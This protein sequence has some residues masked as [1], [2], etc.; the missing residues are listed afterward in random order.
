MPNGCS[1]IE[2]FTS[3]FACVVRASAV[4]A[5]VRASLLMTRDRDYALTLLKQ[6]S[7]ATSRPLFLFTVAGRE[8]YNHEQVQ[9]EVVGSSANDPWDLIRAAQGLSGGG[10]VA[11]EDMAQYLGDERGDRRVRMAIARML[12]SE[13]RHEGGLTLVFVEPPEM[14]GRLPSMLA[15]QIVRL[16]VPYPRSQEIETIAR[17]ELGATLHRNRISFTVEDVRR[18]GALLASELAGLTR[19][20]ARDALRDVLADSPF[21]LAAGLDWLERRKAGYL[22]RELAMEILDRQADEDPIGLDYLVEYLEVIK[23]KLRRF[24]P[25]R[26]RGILLIGPPGTGKTLLARAIG[27]ITGLEPVVAFRIDALMNSLLGETERRFA[28]AFATLEAMAPNIVFIDELEK[29]FGD[30]S[31][32]DGGTMMRVTGRLLSWLSDNPYPNFIVATCN[33]LK[34]MGEIG[35]TMTRSERF[36]RAFFIDVPCTEARRLMLSRWLDGRIDQPEVAA[37]ELASLTERFSGADLRSAVKDAS[38]HAEYRG[39]PLTIEVL[40]QHMERRRMRAIALYDEFQNLRDWG[41]LH[42]DP[43]G[44][45]D[46]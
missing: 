29:A 23:H 22:S 24:G 45:A 28:Q 42:C 31:E 1:D 18:D 7:T 19:S 14:E 8:R 11:F 17:Q 3:A 15:D 20:A 41:R 25:E 30:S 26:A 12:S 37:E 46:L 35:Q 33:S 21:D 4:N 34:R 36:D 9:W 40:K 44:P 10:I 2:T 39:L 16:A 32:R 27:R 13:W 38:N 5:A 6:V 43:A